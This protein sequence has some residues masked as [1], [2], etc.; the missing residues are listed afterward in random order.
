MWG[1]PPRTPSL[2][3]DPL[4]RA[5]TSPA[6]PPACFSSVPCTQHTHAH[7][8]TQKHTHAHTTNVHTQVHTRAMHTQIHAHICAHPAHAQ[9]HAHTMH[10]RHKH[11][12]THTNT[13]IYTQTHAHVHTERGYGR[14]Q[15]MGTKPSGLTVFQKVP[16]VPTSG[17]TCLHCGGPV[18]S[19]SVLPQH[20]APWQHAGA[21]LGRPTH[22]GSPGTAPC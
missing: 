14:G 22:L 13:H 17:C 9:T 8:C 6:W 2:S 11:T 19:P 5:Y 21:R 7:A 18:R 4:A 20:P 3:Q 16:P 12:C 10:T 15:A 1:C